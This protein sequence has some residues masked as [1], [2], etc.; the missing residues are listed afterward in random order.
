MSIFSFEQA[1]EKL[2]RFLS[3]HHPFPKAPSGLYVPCSYFLGI[4]GKRIRPVLCLMGYQLFKDEISDDV[5][6]TALAWELF[7]NFTL[8]HDDI[9]DNSDLRRGSPT[10]H[11][12]Y[13]N[14]AAILSG[15][16]M[17]IYAYKSL[18]NIQDKNLLAAVFQLFNHT[19]IEVCEGQQYDM[20]FENTEH[21]SEA[22]YLKMIGLKTSVLLAA[23]LKSAGIL[24]NASEAD[25]AALYN[26]GLNLGLAFQIQDD[27]LD[28]YGQEEVIGKVPGGDIWANKKTI[29]L[30]KLFEITKNTEHEVILEN[31]LQFTD[32]STKVEAVKE[33]YNEYQ[34][35]EY[36]LQMVK[37][38]SQ[39]SIESLHSVNVAEE[40]KAALIDLSNYLIGRIS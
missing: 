7:H 3:Q 34:I 1:V 5:Y 19:G 2:Q 32:R 33:L 9:M 17:N 6:H 31:V 12:L 39:K 37:M 13:G 26:F 38:Y 23:S 30:T 14:T 36:A 4:G 18:E 15:D 20:D 24:A 11:K 40:R 22:D 27:Y 8:L 10:V 28:A 25:C 16:V 35:D 21:V 29:L